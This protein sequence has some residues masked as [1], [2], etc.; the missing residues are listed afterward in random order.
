MLASDVVDRED[1]VVGMLGAGIDEAFNCCVCAVDIGKVA[2][3]EDADGGAAR[4]FE[5]AADIDGVPSL[6]KK[7]PKAFIA[8]GV[9]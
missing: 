9:P 5:L 2:D 4:G 3:I 8:R 1:E 6:F 7:E